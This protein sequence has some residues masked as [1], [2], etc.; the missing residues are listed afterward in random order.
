MIRAFSR[1]PFGIVPP[2]RSM[3]ENVVSPTMKPSGPF[4]EFVA[5]LPP[6]VA[7]PPRMPVASFSVSVVATL[8]SEIRREPAFRVNALRLIVEEPVLRVIA[9]VP[10][11]V[12][13]STVSPCATVP[14]RSRMPSFNIRLA[15]S[16]S[17][18]LSASY[19]SCKVPPFRVV[20]PEKLFSLVRVSIAVPA[21]TKDSAESTSP[22]C[23][24]KKLTP[25]RM[26]RSVTA[27]TD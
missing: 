21:F 4:V 16:E 8:S 11:I 12:V 7:Q 25:S 5:Q 15:V 2:S 27:S 14:A 6:T 13:S 23:K 3:S 10:L 26:T 9:T 1:L 17:I 20:V 19:A 22:G 18:E 24:A